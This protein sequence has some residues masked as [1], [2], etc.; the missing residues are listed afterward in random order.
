ME[1]SLVSVEPENVP[2]NEQLRTS[3]HNRYAIGTDAVETQDVQ[4]QEAGPGE[5]ILYATGEYAEPVKDVYIYWDCRSTGI[6]EQDVYIDRSLEL[7]DKVSE[8][9]SYAAL[10]KYGG[11]PYYG[12]VPKSIDFC[13]PDLIGGGDHSHVRETIMLDI[14]TDVIIYST[15]GQTS[16]LAIVIVSDDP[17]LYEVCNRLSSSGAHY[18]FY[19]Q[20]PAL[21]GPCDHIH[22]LQTYNVVQLTRGNDGE[23]VLNRLLMEPNIRTF[24]HPPDIHH[25]VGIFDAV[26]VHNGTVRFLKDSDEGKMTILQE[27]ILSVL[28]KSDFLDVRNFSTTQTA[29]W[30][31]NAA[32]TC[33]LLR[34]CYW[35]SRKPG[36]ICYLDDVHSLGEGKHV[37]GLCSRR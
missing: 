11:Y 32:I 2:T 34:R 12:S 16:N 35:N 27:E 4:E 21:F 25:V 5:R 10:K 29:E 3:M 15:N 20:L 26:Q 23:Y 33:G 18:F 37:T 30:Y 9:A 31:L 17:L 14:M 36:I 1:N 19:T 22:C 7:V 6:D 13:E 24:R 28:R 8:G